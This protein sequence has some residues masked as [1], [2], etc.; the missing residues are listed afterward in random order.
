M[1]RHCLLSIYHRWK[2]GHGSSHNTSSTTSTSSSSKAASNLSLTSSFQLMRSPAVH[3]SIGQGDSCLSSS[4]PIM[5]ADDSSFHV[6]EDDTRDS[7]PT[8]SAIHNNEC[9]IFFMK[10]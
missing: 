4:S 5:A 10:C 9:K 6:Y 7:L 8:H 1:S 3:N 2:N